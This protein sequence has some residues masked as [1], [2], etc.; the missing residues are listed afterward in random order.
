MLTVPLNGYKD[1]YDYLRK[2]APYNRIPG[3]RVPTF[4]MNCVNDPFLADTLDYDIFTGNEN[5]V[6]A[7]NLYG[8][9]VG[10][11]ESLF[12]RD[13]WFVKPAMDFL[14]ALEDQMVAKDEPKKEQVAECNDLLEA[15]NTITL[16]TDSTSQADVFKSII[17]ESVL[18]GLEFKSE[19]FQYA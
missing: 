16:I 10:Y 8:G 4:F 1:G 7:T 11:H 14:V 15:K 13:Q 3:I 18:P 9:H 17:D 2:A 12:G 5:T 19:N 6:L